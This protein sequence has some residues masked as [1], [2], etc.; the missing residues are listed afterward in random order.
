MEENPKINAMTPTIFYDGTDLRCLTEEVPARP[1]ILEM[2]EL[3]AMEEF[4]AAICRLKATSVKIGDKY[5]FNINFK[6]GELYKLEGYEVEFEYRA[7]TSI[8]PGDLSWKK[9]DYGTW[10]CSA[11]ENRETV[12]II[13]KTSEKPKSCPKCRT[14][15]FYGCHSMHCPMRTTV[16]DKAEESQGDL[17]ELVAEHIGASIRPGDEKYLTEN[18]H[19][20]RR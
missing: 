7:K 16:P 14:F 4:N 15:D 20:T 5:T 6:E 12:A 9:V 13:T 11:P 3:S 17:W 8:G 10:A 2:E 19:L 1:S 18:F